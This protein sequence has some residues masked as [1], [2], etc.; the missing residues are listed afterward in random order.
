[1]G[2]VVGARIPSKSLICPRQSYPNRKIDLRSLDVEV[3]QLVY[4][5]PHSDVD[6]DLEFL[7]GRD[8]L[9]IQA[10]SECFV[11]HL[12][13][14]TKVWGARIPDGGADD[15]LGEGCGE[16]EGEKENHV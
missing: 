16:E 4:V 13:L 15:L 7:D 11:L 10:I 8:E 2:D 5:Q 12:T 14:S 3:D 1:M 9:I 6:R